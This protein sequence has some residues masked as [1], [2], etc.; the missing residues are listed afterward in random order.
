MMTEYDTYVRTEWDKFVADPKRWRASLDATKEISVQRVLDVGCGAGQELLPFLAE[1]EAL[2]IGIDVAPGVGRMGR[3]LFASCGYES[4]VVF[5]RGTAESLPFCDAAFDVII[6]RIAL[7]Y[8]DNRSAL[9]EIARALRLSG[10][11]LLKIHHPLFY[12]RK[13]GKGVV[14]LNARSTMHATRVL[15]AGT[16]YH[17]I[18]KQ[19]RNGVLG[20]EVFQTK[21]LLKRELMLHGLAI[22]GELPDS[23]PATPS[24]IIS[25]V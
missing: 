18:G 4:G 15:T 10:V 6:C 12:L 11:L 20:T 16:V 22:I 25:K 14:T 8:T 24:F 1:R 23:N 17:A 7:P 21:W 9:K 5:L 13:L 19:V 2:C 3:E